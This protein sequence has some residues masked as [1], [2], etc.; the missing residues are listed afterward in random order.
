M[1]P[2]MT[3]ATGNRT[4]EKRPL[5]RNSLRV[6]Q[7]NVAVHCTQESIDQQANCMGSVMEGILRQMEDHH[8]WRVDE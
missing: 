7:V 1:K 6:R 2:V 8:E 4:E 5:R 3:K